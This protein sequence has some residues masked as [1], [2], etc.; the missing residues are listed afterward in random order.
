LNLKY[1]IKEDNAVEAYH[2]SRQMFVIIGGQLQVAEPG[3]PYSHA[4]WFEKEGWMADGDDRLMDEAVRGI[5]DSQGDIYFYSGYDFRIDD[6][7]EAVF[8][9][10][11]PGLV[12]S[13]ELKPEAKLYGGVQKGEP[14]EVWPPIRD[15]GEISKI[16]AR[17][18]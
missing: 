13:L 8:M 15:Y 12:E 10:N 5:I 4:S 14:G 16:L 7:I 1:G 11:L 9:E 18:L 6:D 3:L 17:E 2:R